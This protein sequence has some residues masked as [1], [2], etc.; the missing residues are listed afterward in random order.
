VLIIRRAL[1]TSK[2]RSQLSSVDTNV[3]ATHLLMAICQILT[4]TIHEEHNTTIV[5]TGGIGFDRTL[6]VLGEVLHVTCNC[7]VIWRLIPDVTLL[8]ICAPKR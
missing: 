8:E 4:S 5:T 1:T 7:N 6:P 3:K 2:T